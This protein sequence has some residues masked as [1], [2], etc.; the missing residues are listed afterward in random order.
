[1]L[2]EN[3]GDGKLRKRLHCSQ[4]VTLNLWSKHNFSNFSS[5]SSA[6]NNNFKFL[7]KYFNTKM[8]S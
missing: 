6:S 2:L 3:P 5:P 1:M 4:F 7:F 8:I